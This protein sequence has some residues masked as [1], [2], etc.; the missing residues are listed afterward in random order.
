MSKWSKKHTIILSSVLTLAVAIVSLV[1]IVKGVSNNNDGGG[2][3]GGSNHKHKLFLDSVVAPTNTTKGHLHLKCKCGFTYDDLLLCKEHNGLYVDENN[4]Y[5]LGKYPQA[6]IEDEIGISYLNSLVSSSNGKIDMNQWKEYH[7]NYSA[8]RYYDTTFGN[9]YYV[10]LDVD[11]NGSFDYRG[12]FCEAKATYFNEK[13]HLEEGEVKWFRY[14][15]VQWKELD[16]TGDNHLLLSYFLIEKQVWNPDA[17]KYQQNNYYSKSNL[18]AWLKTTFYDQLFNSVEKT[19]ISSDAHSMRFDNDNIFILGSTDMESFYFITHYLAE[20]TSY[21]DGLGAETRDY[22]TASCT[23][24]IEQDTIIGVNGDNNIG[25]YRS[26]Y[27]S[28]ACLKV[29]PS[30]IVKY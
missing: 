28:T 15:P 24:G 30:I 17:T 26:L 25:T 8:Y 23:N 5:W 1:F 21:V 29:R 7:T 20:F 22:F 10:D 14:E 3:G 4:D 12:L 16:S 13:M 19:Y 18:R 2:S 27:Y 9:Y 11:N 6:L